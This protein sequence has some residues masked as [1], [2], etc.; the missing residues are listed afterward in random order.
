[1]KPIKKI[2][3]LTAAGAIL[4][5]SLF[6]GC[7]LFNAY[8][9]IP[10]L[11]DNAASYDMYSVDSVDM[12]LIDVNGATYAP[13]GTLKGRFKDEYVREC[14]GYVDGDKNTRIYSLCEDPYD[15]YIVM[16]NT[17]GV[18]EQPQFWR[19]MSTYGEDIFTPGYIDSL[20]YEEWGSSGCYS[21]MRE[22]RIDVNLEAEDV[23]ELAMDFTI[24]GD[25]DGSAGVRNAD[26]SEMKDDVY[27]LSIPEMHLHDK[28]DFDEP[29]DVEIHFT[30]TT[31]SGDNVALDDVY[32]GTVKL[33]D[34]D[35]LTLTGNAQDGYKIC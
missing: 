34:Q 28:Y 5:A 12:M 13:F 21:E 30:V 14:L 6:S 19:D 32:T 4:F 1:M 8:A 15:D 22:F 20:E 33:G 26:W 2:K 25:T 7:S 11:P 24:N 31:M 29:F 35:T 3:V 17:N 9:G 10:S 23:M 27:E 18:M 16:I